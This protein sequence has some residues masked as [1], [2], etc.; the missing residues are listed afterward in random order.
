MNHSMS[1]KN[2]INSFFVA[3]CE[4]LAKVD[5]RIA[6]VIPAAIGVIASMYGIWMELHGQGELLRQGGSMAVDAYIN[7]MQ[8]N[9]I[10]SITEYVK[11]AFAGEL[12]SF[13]GNAQGVGFATSVVGPVIAATSVLLARGLKNAKGLSEG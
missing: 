12:P 8:I 11:L 13:G 3:F 1:L 9:P 10:D 5:M 7:A 2:K 6:V 4:R